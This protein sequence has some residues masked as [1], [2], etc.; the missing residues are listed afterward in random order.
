[1]FVFIGMKHFDHLSIEFLGVVFTLRNVF[2]DRLKR[3]LDVLVHFE[4]LT[5]RAVAVFT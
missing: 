4:G 1:M 2:D 5:I 3:S